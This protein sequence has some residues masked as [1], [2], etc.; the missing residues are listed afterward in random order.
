MGQSGQYNYARCASRGET[1]AAQLAMAEFVK[2]ALNVLFL[3]NRRYIPYYK[4]SFRA[5]R[6]LDVLSD[7][8]GALEYLI[9]SGN[10]PSEIEQKQKKIEE[11]C[12][13]ISKELVSLGLSNFGGCEMEAHAY[14]VNGRVGDSNVRNLHVLYAV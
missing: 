5:L 8:S 1:G 4:W 2:S 7:M 13:T 9:S 11:V 14:E 6:E 3:I 12:D 10:S